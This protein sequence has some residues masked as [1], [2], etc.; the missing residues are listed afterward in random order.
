MKFKTLSLVVLVLAVSGCGGVDPNSPQ[1]QR[2][3]IFKQ[4]GNQRLTLDQG[5]LAA[6]TG[7]HKSIAPQ[8]CRGVQHLRTH[9]R[10]YP[11]RLG[12]HLPAATTKQPS[13]GHRPFDKVDPHRTRRLRAKLDKLQT[14]R[15]QLQGKLR[16]RIDRQSQPFGPQCQGRQVA[17][18]KRR[19]GN[20]GAK[21]LVTHQL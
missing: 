16:L 21:P 14:G 10:L 18:L 6:Q 11:E 1:G 19:K 3:T 8:S 12:D 9:A 15:A 7:Q 17:W 4:S 2:Q 13:M 5:H 20:S